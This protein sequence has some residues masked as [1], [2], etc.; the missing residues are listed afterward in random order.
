MAEVRVRLPLGALIGDIRAWESLE[1]RLPRAQ[2]SAGSN[3]AALT[4]SLRCGL[5]V[6]QLPVKETIA[7]STPAAAASR[8]GTSR[9]A[10]AAVL[11]TVERKPWGFDSLSL[12]SCALG[13]AAKV[14]ALGTDRR[15][16]Y[17]RGGFNSHRAL[18]LTR[19]FNAFGDRLTVGCLA[20]NQVVEVQ[21]LLPELGQA[22]ASAKTKRSGV[23][24]AGSD[25]WL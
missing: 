4:D 14:P 15:L 6:R 5:T 18:Y 19:P 9:L 11:K 21:I 2:E 23:V 8:G 1:F 10:T 7:G 16:V 12:R 17:W 20:L 3:P 13:R 24:A 22:R 25:A